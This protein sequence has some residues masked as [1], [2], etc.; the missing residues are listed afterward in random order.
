MKIFVSGNSHATEKFLG[1]KQ[2][3][4]SCPG[5]DL[6]TVLIANQDLI[7]RITVLWGPRKGASLFLKTHFRSVS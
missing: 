5:L 7:W 3:N 2:N 1:H 4:M 6:I